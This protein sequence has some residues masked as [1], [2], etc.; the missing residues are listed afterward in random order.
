MTKNVVISTAHLS[1][2]DRE[3]DKTYGATMHNATIEA[4]S[5][6]QK[7]ITNIKEE[8]FFCLLI[9]NE[10]SGIFFFL[11]PSMRMQKKN[12]SIEG[13]FKNHYNLF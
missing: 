6:M 4:R 9:G 5:T 3:P 12:C 7:F 11:F 1:G 2:N 13:Y 10:I 8:E